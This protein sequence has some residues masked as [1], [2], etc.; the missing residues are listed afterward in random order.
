[1]PRAAVNLGAWLVGAVVS[2][3]V[4]VVALSR[5]DAGLAGGGMQPLSPD[6]VTRG[7]T[8]VPPATPADPRATSRS[9]SDPAVRNPSV[10]AVPPSTAASRPVRTTERAFTSRGGSFVARCTDG[11]V[12]LTSWSPAPGYQSTGVERGPGEGAQ[13]TFQSDLSHVRVLLRCV[14]G[15]PQATID[16]GDGHDDDHS[17]G[18]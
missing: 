8:E 13:L 16:P 9:A 10:T 12:Y 15:V 11:L 7:M 2:V 4:G 5:I 3:T 1:M 14:A 6:S 18:H 17:P